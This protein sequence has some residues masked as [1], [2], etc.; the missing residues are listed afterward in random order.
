[1]FVLAGIDEKDIQSSMKQ[2][3]KGSPNQIQN[4]LDQIADQTT[5]HFREVWQEY[6]GISFS[7]R[8]NGD[9]IVPGIKEANTHDFGKRSDGFK[10]FVTFLLM[11][12]VKVKSKQMENTLLLIDEPEISLHP[13]VSGVRTSVTDLAS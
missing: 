1:M 10:R 7:L 2:E 13:S 4:Y 6:R 3:L 11:I 8:L 12:S 9:S 5:A